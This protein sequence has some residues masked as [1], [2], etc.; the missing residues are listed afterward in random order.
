MQAIPIDFNEYTEE[1]LLKMPYKEAVQGLNEHL[2][3]FCEYYVESHNRKTAMIKAGFSIEL[4]DGTYAR[5]ILQ[6]KQVQVYIQWLKVRVLNQH[7]LNA[8][9]LIEEWCRIAFSDITDFVDIH[10]TSIRLKSPKEMDGQLIKSIKTTRDGVSIE[11]YDKMKALDSLAKY[12]DDMPKE[13]KQKLEERKLELMEQEFQLKKKM[14]DI[15]DVDEEDDG[16]IEAIKKSAKTVWE[17]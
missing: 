16:F 12:I 9:D 8:Y 11:L 3:S 5:R 1:E 15:T 10:P 7:L 2:K 4:A 6:K 17:N 13:W 14:A